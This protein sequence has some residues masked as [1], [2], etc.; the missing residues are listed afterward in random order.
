M[1]IRPATSAQSVTATAAAPRCS[2]PIDSG[3]DR[4]RPRKLPGTA[5]A[6][7]LL[8]PSV[9]DLDTTLRLDFRSDTI[10]QPT[11]AMREAMRSAEVGDDVFGEDP[12]INALEAHAAQ[13][14][15]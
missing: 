13:V 9:N 4:T 14:F 5:M 10:T 15:G 7:T 1:A 12:S 8:D 3:T 2:E 6:V 11:A